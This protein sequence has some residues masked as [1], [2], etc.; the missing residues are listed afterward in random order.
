M[1]SGAILEF[2]SPERAQSAQ[3]V[4]KPNVSGE[5][6]I[7]P[8]TEGN[9]TRAILIS[10]FILGTTMLSAIGGTLLIWAYLR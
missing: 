2:V 10:A 7:A 8:R 4:S 3:S 5:P 1:S 6:V 9:H